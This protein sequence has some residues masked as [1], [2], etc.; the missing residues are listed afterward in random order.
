VRRATLDLTLF[1]FRDEVGLDMKKIFIYIIFI[2]AGLAVRSQSLPDSLQQKYNA[3]KSFREKGQ[4]ITNYVFELKGSSLE[5]L[6]ILLPQLSYFT[7]KKDDAGIGYTKLYIG[8]SFVKMSDYSEALKYGIDAMKIFEEVQDS[9]ALL[10][11]YTEIG[12]SYLNSKNIDESLKEWQ[13]AL[14]IARIYDTHYYTIYLGSIADCFN[15]IEQP[16]S[17][18]PYIQEAL[19]VAYSRKDSGDISNCL[20]TMGDTY[21]IMKQNEIARVFY[22]QS[23]FFTKK[24]NNFLSM[25]KARFAN[26]LNNI[27]QTYFNASQYDSSLAYA[28][29]ALA[30]DYA[31]YLIVAQYSYEL[32]YKTFDKENKTDS[33]NKYFRLA[34]EIKDS[35]FSDEKSRN[36]QFQKFKEQIRQQELETQKQLLASKHKENI[37]NA[38]IA[39]GITLFTILFLFLSR[40]FITNIRLIKFFG[41]LALLLVF[42]FINIL[43]HSYLERLTDNSQ[44]LTLIL[45]VGI[46]ALLIPLH[47]RV[48]KWTIT[49]VVEKN[50]AVRLANAKR[51]IEKLEVKDKSQVE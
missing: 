25:Y 45:L 47:H 48:E 2:C 29:Q 51:T 17:A 20:S 28:R 34:A 6:K 3:A 36:I 13:K 42:E 11:T 35:L 27:S 37:E 9:F 21:V 44:V 4:I 8:I 7:N 12:N 22:R 33:S 1:T 18:M 30:Y 32:M 41:I 38:L 23:M 31:D 15:S 40:S 50:K 24:T 46:A 14:P 26:N 10:K 49:K 43:V 19:R 16:D 5:Q 39:L